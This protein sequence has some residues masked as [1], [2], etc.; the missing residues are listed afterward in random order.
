MG[1]LLAA[2]SILQFF[3]VLIIFILVLGVTAWVTRWTANYQSQM[4]RGNIEIIETARI[5]QNKYL[6]IV[7]AGKTYMVIAVCKDTVTMLGE[8]S[9]DELTL[10]DPSAKRTSFKE[11]FDKTIKLNSSDR[12]GTK[13]EDE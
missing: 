7:R 1:T 12:T 13:D 2:G 10:D 8:V 4:S 6:Q 9:E 11:L 3:T 5:S